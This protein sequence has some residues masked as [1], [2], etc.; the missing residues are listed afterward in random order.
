M[1]RRT[2]LLATTCGAAPLTTLEFS[3]LPNFCSHEHWGRIDSIGTVPEGFRADMEPGARPTRQTGFMDLL[4]APYF[5]GWL[6]DGTDLTSFSGRGR[7]FRD[8]M[9]ESGWEAIIL[10]GSALERHRF[11]GV[12]QCT[13]RGILQLCGIDGEVRWSGK[14]T[15]AEMTN[16]AVAV[17]G[18]GRR[19]ELRKG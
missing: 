2:F 11:T 4:L 13:R 7:A 12:Y 19:V 18:M 6:A 14:R 5:R 15:P 3:E 16:N 8:L 1:K 17:Y 10:L 9:R